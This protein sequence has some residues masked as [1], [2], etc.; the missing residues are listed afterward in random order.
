MNP[1]VLDKLDFDQTIDEYAAMAGVSPSL[2]LADVAVRQKRQQRAK[3]QQ[4]E[5]QMM[6]QREMIEQA[7]LVSETQP[8]TEEEISD[9]V[10]RPV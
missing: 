5:Q 2:V 8:A 7:K 4:Q 3:Q 1:E 9:M 6:Q 10:G